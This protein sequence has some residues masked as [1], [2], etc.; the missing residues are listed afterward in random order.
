MMI[1]TVVIGSMTN[2]QKAGRLLRAH[3]IRTRLTKTDSTLRG[4]CVYGLEIN[5]G[6]LREACAALRAA[7][8]EHRLL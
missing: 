7:G 5:E 1:R 6:N 3:G 4:G 8:I 2:T